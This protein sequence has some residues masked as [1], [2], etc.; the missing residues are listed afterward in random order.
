MKKIGRVLH[1]SPGDKAVIKTLKPLMIGEKVF[2][3]KRSFVGRV[4]DVFGP[5]KSPYIEVD[6][7]SGEA[8]KLIGKMLY[9]S[10][11]EKRKRR[12]R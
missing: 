9:Q 10:L 3:E 4:S 11:P 5:I 1:I 2:D 8:S 12:R 7:T 6:V